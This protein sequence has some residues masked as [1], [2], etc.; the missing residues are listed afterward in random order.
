MADNHASL[1]AGLPGGWLWA[2]W[3]DAPAADLGRNTAIYYWRT[4]G[5]LSPARWTLDFTVRW[6]GD[7]V[8]VQGFSTENYLV[9]RT[10]E[11][12]SWLGLGHQGHGIGTFMRQNLCAFVFDHLDAEEV[13][14]AAYV[15]NPASLA[16]SKK[17]GYSTN[18]HFREQRR[19]GELAISQKLSLN[20]RDLRRHD[21]DLQVDGLDPVRQLLGLGKDASPHNE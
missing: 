21:F 18:G 11:T 17:V 16:V 12:G 4:R 14:S 20:K 19:P 10:G 9:T 5:E 2:T 7:T 15:D 8:G 13:T 1:Y 6:R 3:T